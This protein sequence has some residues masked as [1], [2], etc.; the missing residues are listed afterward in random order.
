MPN[1]HRTLHTQAAF[2]A[3]RA[4]L[5][6]RPWAVDDLDAVLDRWEGR[7]YKKAVIFVDNAGSDVVLGETHRLVQT[8]G[9]L[10]CNAAMQSKDRKCRLGACMHPGP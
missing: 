7:P 4:G 6:E 1:L 5:V 9:G 2:A 8:T 3:T 10:L